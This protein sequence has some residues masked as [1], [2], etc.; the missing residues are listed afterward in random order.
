MHTCAEPRAMHTV[1]I[2]KSARGEPFSAPHYLA[3]WVVRS[4]E[5]RTRIRNKVL[6]KSNALNQTTLWHS[7]LIFFI[8]SDIYSSSCVK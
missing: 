2:N 8:F 3:Q 4:L 1:G 5:Q 6:D 7:C